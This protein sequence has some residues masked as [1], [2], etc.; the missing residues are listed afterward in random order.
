MEFELSSRIYSPMIEKLWEARER[1]KKVI[2]NYAKYEM[3][4]A[5]ATSAE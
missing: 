4:H 3:T 1:V 2:G 5:I